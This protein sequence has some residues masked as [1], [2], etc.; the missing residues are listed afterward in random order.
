MSRDTA[1]FCIALTTP[2]ALLRE[3]AGIA[4]ARDLHLTILVHAAFPSLPVA[5]Y[6]ALPYGT[7]SIPEE[8]PEEIGARRK[9]LE[10]RIAEI[11]AIMDQEGAS[12]DIRPL[13]VSQPDLR[14][15]IA[16]AART[17]DAAFFA[18][19][20]REQDGAF[21]QMLQAV[22]FDAPIPAVINTLPGLAP[23]RV[24]LAWDESLACAR[25]AHLALP[26]LKAAREVGI[27]CF[28]QPA[29]DVAGGRIEPGAG[30]AAWLSHHGCSVTLT[31]LPAGKREIG[32]AIL[33]HARETGAGLIVAGGYGHARL[34]QAVFGGT[35]RTLIEQTELPVLLAH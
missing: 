22:L 28:D 21:A 11:D 16:Q 6:A 14:E 17:A 7:I 23:E 4:L 29:Q 27:V 1:L 9:A 35:S 31:Q 34:R 12:A 10:A 30:A 20:L 18:P 19:E 5:A 33:D 15:S 3:A 24:L 26:C 2:D 13:F 32:G 25:A 8:W